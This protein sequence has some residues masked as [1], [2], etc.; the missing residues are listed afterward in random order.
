M[1]VVEHVECVVLQVRMFKHATRPSKVM[2]DDDGYPDVSTSGSDDMVT[3]RR[4]RAR[5]LE[6]GTAA[7]LQRT[8]W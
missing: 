6:V 5:L 8:H 2:F 4:H 3:N 1:L 7:N